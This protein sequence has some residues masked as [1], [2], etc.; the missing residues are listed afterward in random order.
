MP[1]QIRTPRLIASWLV[2]I[3]V[4]G[5]LSG[6]VAALVPLAAGGLMGGSAARRHHHAS[7]QLA[8]DNH[9][10]PQASPSATAAPAV[11]PIAPVAPPPAAVAGTA[12][13]PRAP[14][15]APLPVSSA[16]IVSATPVAP[17]VIPTATTWDDVARSTARMAVRTPDRLKTD[18]LRLPD[19]RTP[20]LCG[21]RPTAILID[22]ATLGSGDYLYVGALQ[23]MGLEIVLM[24]RSK[25]LPTDQL[26]GLAKQGIAA[27]IPGQ[28][29]FFGAPGEE[30]KVR[31]AI[32]DRYCVVGLVGNRAADFPGN[33]LP[34]TPTAR[35]GWFLVNNR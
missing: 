20:S 17:A 31:T 10:L 27:P 34:G 26:K 13:T 15:G 8:T 9:Q 29:L 16:P 1:N 7:P 24:S 5:M 19:D 18:V 35:E 4:G 28:T 3:G 6:C 14:V 21:A 12:P 22:T 11:T 30:A 25:T 33:A 2:V 23:T 32:A